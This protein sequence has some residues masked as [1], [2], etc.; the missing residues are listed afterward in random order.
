MDIAQLSGKYNEVVYR[1]RCV[2]EIGGTE[3]TQSS[4]MFLNLVYQSYVILK[5]SER[6]WG[7]LSH[8]NRI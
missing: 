1:N 7:D 4:L 8:K 2:H 3:N 5:K 6:T